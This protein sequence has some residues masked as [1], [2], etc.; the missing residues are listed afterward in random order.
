MALCCTRS[1]IARGRLHHLAY[2]LDNREDVLRD[3]DLFTEHGVAIE[4]GPGKHAIGQAFFVYVYEPGVNRIELCAARYQ[5]NAPDWPPV[6]W[7]EAARA[8]GQAW[9]AATVAR[10]YIYGTPVPYTEP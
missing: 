7:T 3:A 9:G 8:R 10:F 5:I 1:S 4:H 6:R 2:R